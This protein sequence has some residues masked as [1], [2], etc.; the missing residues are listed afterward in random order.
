MID[1]E[2]ALSRTSHV[3]LRIPERHAVGF[4]FGSLAWGGFTDRGYGDDGSR[5]LDD[6][7]RLDVVGTEDDEQMGYGHVGDEYA[8]EECDLGA[9]VWDHGE[10]GGVEVVRR[11]LREFGIAEFDVGRS[12]AE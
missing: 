10:G 3:R 2:L 11:F 1:E 12:W 7:L 4:D 8:R 6:R 5:D 9:Q